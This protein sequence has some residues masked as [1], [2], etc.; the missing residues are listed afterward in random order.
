MRGEAPGDVRSDVVFDGV[1]KSFGEVVRGRRRRLEVASGRVLRSSAHPDQRQDHIPADDRGLRAPNIGTHAA[2]PARTSLACPYD[3]DVD[4][5]FQDYP[6]FPHMTVA[7]TSSLG[8]KVATSRRATDIPGRGSTQAAPPR[9]LQATDKSQQLSGGQ[10][11]RVALATHA[12]E[13]ADT[14][15]SSTSRSARSTSSSDRTCRS[16]S[17]HIQSEVGIAFIYVT[18]DQTRRSR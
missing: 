18:H 6:L 13:P 5:V 8:L 11:Q 2:P 17:K 1:T 9:R 16:S 3:R 4:T 12:R 7:E 14:C 10:R 15:C